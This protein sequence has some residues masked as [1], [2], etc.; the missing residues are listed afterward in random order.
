[1]SA[2]LTNDNRLGIYLKYR[3]AKL[4]PAALGFPMTRRRTPGLRREEVAQ[5]IGITPDTA[6]K[7]MAAC[8]K[9]AKD[10]CAR[11][12]EQGINPQ[13]HIVID[14]CIAKAKKT[15][16]EWKAWKASSDN[17]GSPQQ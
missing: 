16:E 12:R 17:A 1:M 5:V 13:A 6:I 9:L 2:P 10:G 11:Y 3:R 8:V 7:Y 4:D 14:P 15:Y